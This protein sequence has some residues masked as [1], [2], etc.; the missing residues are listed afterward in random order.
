MQLTWKGFRFAALALCL[1]GML[2]PSP[3]RADDPWG[4][5]IARGQLLQSQG[6]YSEAEEAYQ[7]ALARPKESQ[8]PLATAQ[9]MNALALVKQIRG[10]YPSA[11]S[12]NEAAREICKEH[13]SPR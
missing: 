6:H 3:C 2:I 11:E 12:L 10:D 8:K 7:S 5:L 1:I 4:E 9:S 13:P